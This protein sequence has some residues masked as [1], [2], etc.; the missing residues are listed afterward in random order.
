MQHD[1]SVDAPQDALKWSKNL[2]RTRAAQPAKTLVQKLMAVLQMDL[3][4]NKAAFGERSASAAQERQMLF[5]AGANGIDLR[6]KKGEKGFDLKGQILGEGFAE[7]R[8]RF[9][10][11]ET[12]TNRL[13]EFSFSEIPAGRYDLTLFSGE[14]EIT[15]ENLEIK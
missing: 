12:T 7:S 5:S 6:I 13:S 3:A 8:V 9:G 2:F 15:V 14:T 1:D 4:P 10:D 11:L